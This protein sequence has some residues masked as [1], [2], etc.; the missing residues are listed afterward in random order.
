MLI[1]PDRRQRYDE[2]G[3]KGLRFPPP[4]SKEIPYQYVGDPLAL[5]DSFFTRE[6]PLAPAEYPAKMAAPW[7]KPSVTDPTLEVEVPCSL[8][9]LQT[10][11]T[12]RVAV[13]RTRLGPEG[14]AYKEEK[15]IALPIRAGL[16]SGTRI[17][18]PGEGNHTNKNRSP[19]DLVLIVV[20]RSMSAEDLSAASSDAPSW[21][22]RNWD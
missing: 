18:F 20:Q 15:L 9:D 22:K 19:G 2:L 21:F 16:Q 13:A 1:Y 4:G 17:T 5:F 10:G 6:S 3:E 14:V 12:R 7:E 11:A 8:H